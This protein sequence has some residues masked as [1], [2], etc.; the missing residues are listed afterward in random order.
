M[1]FLIDADLPRSVAGLLQRYGHETTDVRDIGLRDANDPTI[2]QYAQQHRLGL[3][4]GDFDFSDIRT[5]LPAPMPALW[6]W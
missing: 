4:T 6:C 3:R 5:S 1:R 2:A